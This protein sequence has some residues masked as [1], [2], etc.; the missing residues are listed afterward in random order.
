MLKKPLR[1]WPQYEVNKDEIS[2]TKEDIP[3]PNTS[4][5]T[6]NVEDVVLPA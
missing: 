2:P 5:M 3:W 1:E 4:S 6:E